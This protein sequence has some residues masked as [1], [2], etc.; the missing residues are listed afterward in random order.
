MLRELLQLSYRRRHQNWLARCARLD[1]Q[2]V[3]FQ[4]FEARPF[5]VPTAPTPLSPRRPVVFYPTLYARYAGL[6]QLEGSARGLARLC[7]QRRLSR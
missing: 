3:L 5:F 1:I 7:D 4:T 2:T 6:Y